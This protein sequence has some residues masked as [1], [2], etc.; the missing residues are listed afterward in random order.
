MHTVR[1]SLHYIWPLALLL[2]LI[3]PPWPTAAQRA[4]RWL[5]DPALL[6]GLRT[7]GPNGGQLVPDSITDIALEDGANGW[8]CLARRSCA[9]A[10]ICRRLFTQIIRSFFTAR[11]AFS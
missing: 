3:A 11:V 1:H 2:L 10:G 7:I 5:A 9:C 8:A 4:R 6:T